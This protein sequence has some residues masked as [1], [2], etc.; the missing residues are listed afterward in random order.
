VVP[1]TLGS[2]EGNNAF[3][4][5]G[6]K[7]DTEKSEPFLDTIGEGVTSCSYFPVVEFFK[8]CLGVVPGTRHTIPAIGLAVLEMLVALFPAERKRLAGQ[9]DNEKARLQAL[10]AADE[11]AVLLLPTLPSTAFRHHEGL[12][13]F[14]DVASTCLFNVVEFPATN[15]PLGVQC[16]AGPWQDHKSIAVGLHL[17]ALGIARW[18]PPSGTR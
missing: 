4:F 5:W 17:E 18:D 14:F 12:L 9:F 3:F 6:A 10:L 11:N 8:S 16:V 2:L 1:L 13:R 7:M 15:I